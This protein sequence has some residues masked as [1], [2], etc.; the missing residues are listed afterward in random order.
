MSEIAGGERLAAYVRQLEE[1]ADLPAFAHQIEQVMT[2]TG[3]TDT[4]VWQLT[5]MILKSVSL[6]GKVLRAANSVHFNRSGQPILS[7]SRAVGLLGLETIRS[8]ATGVLLFEHFKNGP[9]SVRE[10]LLVSV[11]T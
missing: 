5:D 7:V 1:S 3:A 10:L 2:A 6:T 9:A 8:L 4:S 11:L